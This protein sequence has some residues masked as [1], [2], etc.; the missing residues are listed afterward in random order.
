MGNCGALSED[1]AWEPHIPF[2]K[3]NE[4]EAVVDDI[5][6]KLASLEW[7]ILC[8]RVHQQ[9]GAV[10]RRIEARKRA[11]KGLHKVPVRPPEETCSETVG[12]RAHKLAT[13]GAMEQASVP[14]GRQ[15]IE[16][17]CHQAAT[18]AHPRSRSQMKR[19]RKLVCRWSPVQS[20]SSS[21]TAR[22]SRGAYDGG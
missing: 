21:V 6:A 2:G 15:L 14:L 1:V 8:L 9:Q 22:L 20:R 18:S 13:E 11:A 7:T 12:R 4:G 19:S 17:M 16:K 10:L 5:M 3:D